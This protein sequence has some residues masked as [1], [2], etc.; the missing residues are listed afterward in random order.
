M[1]MIF[2]FTVLFDMVPFTDIQ[3]K[4][5]FD[6]IAGEGDSAGL[7]IRHMYGRSP[8]DWQERLRR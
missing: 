2:E 6:E 4:S 1:L 5:N 7:N 8:Y 3:E